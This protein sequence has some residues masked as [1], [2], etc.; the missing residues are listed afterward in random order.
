M[1]TELVASLRQ[2]IRP[3]VLH[4]IAERLLLELGLHLT[5]S[6]LLAF[7][8][9]GWFF[10]ELSLPSLG[11][12]LPRFLELSF[13]VHTFLVCGGARTRNI[14]RS[15]SAMSE[16]MACCCNS[17]SSFWSLFR[18]R[19]FLPC[20]V[21]TVNRKELGDNALARLKSLCSR[22]SFH[23]STAFLYCRQIRA[24]RASKS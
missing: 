19:S 7:L 13:E 12:G 20:R 3:Y 4:E 21:S 1:L 14:T 23:L 18:G 8:S 16:H 15:S 10:F 24:V 22:T 2:E 5:G 17:A 6:W 11:L 9:V